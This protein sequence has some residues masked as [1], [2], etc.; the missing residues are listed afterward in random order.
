MSKLLIALGVILITIAVFYFIQL[1]YNYLNYF[2]FTNYDYGVLTGKILI[3][4]I[5]LLAFY[6]GIKTKKK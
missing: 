4:L 3:F 5:G 6:F 1:A 2:E